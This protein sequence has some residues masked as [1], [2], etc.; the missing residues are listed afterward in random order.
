M[1][2]VSLTPDQQRQQR[3][4]AVLARGY[5]RLRTQRLLVARVQTPSFSDNSSP[6]PQNPLALLPQKSVTGDDR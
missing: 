2:S 4:A 5:L 1:T 6:L 3:V